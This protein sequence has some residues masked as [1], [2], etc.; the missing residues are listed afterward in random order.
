M[1]KGAY[2]R[3]RFG[4][5]RGLGLPGAWAWPERGAWRGVVGVGRTGG[6]WEVVWA[7]RFLVLACGKERCDVRG[8]V[9]GPPP[10]AGL[11]RDRR[12][13]TVRDCL[14]CRGCGVWEGSSVL[15][16]V[17]L[18]RGYWRVLEECGGQI[19]PDC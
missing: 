2:G 4:D 14:L 9:G 18:G 5:G 13:V 1:H 12:E 16:W 19:T 11:R 15:L 10:V 6:Q 7:W 8:L 17:L 3:A